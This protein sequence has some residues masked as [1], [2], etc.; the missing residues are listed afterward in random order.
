MT[1]AE[2][3]S[4][5]VLQATQ[6]SG[7][8]DDAV[9]EHVR[10]MY[11]NL[12]RH[13]HRLLV[14]GAEHGRGEDDDDDDDNST[15]TSSPA[16]RTKQQQRRQQQKDPRLRVTSKVN[17]VQGIKAMLPEDTPSARKPGA[18]AMEEATRLDHATARARA[19]AWYHVCYHPSELQRV[20]QEARGFGLSVAPV[21]LSFAWIGVDILC[22]HLVTD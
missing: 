19:F 9:R 6:H 13:Y 22:Q 1:E 12:R 18:E 15:D 4:G 5:S 16:A 10:N 21:F 17:V 14:C 3:A 2:V 20:Q 8:K 11:V 7:R